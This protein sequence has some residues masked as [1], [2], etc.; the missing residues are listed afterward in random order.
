MC[1]GS[2]DT[3]VALLLHCIA[4]SATMSGS[5]APGSQLIWATPAAEDEAGG[6]VI[7]SVS[8]REASGSGAPEDSEYSALAPFG[9]WLL[10]SKGT[11]SG[12]S[13]VEMSPRDSSG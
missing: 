1:Q 4:S 11:S 8:G 5:G 3:I 7:S 10:D 2:L 12:P 6:T 13:S 9:S